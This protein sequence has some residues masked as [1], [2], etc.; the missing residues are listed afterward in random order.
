MAL[1][2]AR[3]DKRLADESLAKRPE[4]AFAYFQNAVALS[5]LV[6]REGMSADAGKSLAESLERCRSQLSLTTRACPSCNGSGRRTIQFQSLG[7]AGDKSTH[8]TM[9]TLQSA[10]G[11]VCTGCGGRGVVVAGRSA[12]ELRVL[13][14]Q[15]RRD[16]ETR[17]QALGRVASGRVW[18][19]QDL[20][21]LLDVRAQALIRTASPTPCNACMGVGNQDCARCKGAG[22]VKCNGEGCVDGWVTRKDPNALSPKTAISRRTPCLT[23]QGSGFMAC[24]DCRGVGTI[25]C[26]ACNGT[27]RSPVCRDCGGQGWGVCTKCQGTGSVSGNVCPDCRGK[28]ERL[29]PKC[30]GEGC[31]VK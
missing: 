16:F 26:K 13:I 12:D 31:D 9:G 30:H 19:P 22:R 10:D 29:C 17:Q 23:C 6:K 20:Q 21:P 24:T 8:A 7:G 3:A 1:E 5:R 15:G 28:N 18:V 27:G 25:P 4:L 14:A 2:A 11:P